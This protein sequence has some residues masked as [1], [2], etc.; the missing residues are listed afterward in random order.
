VAELP[1]DTPLVY[2]DECGVERHVVRKR[3]RAPRGKRIVVKRPGKREKRLNVVAGECDNE[4]IA[5]YAYDWTTKY[6]W[7]EI[8]FEW[9]LCPLLRLNSVVF[10]DNA[11]WHRKSVLEQIARF[12]SFTIIWLPT[13][14]P[15]KNRIEQ[16][17]A[18]LKFWLQ[19]NIND[20]PSVQDAVKDYFRS[21]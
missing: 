9:Y 1:S 19:Y 8:W 13:Y 2:V 6:T 7:F 15:D 10:M 16:R 20:Y 12:Y 4:V 18:N 11:S 21:D 17:W 5:P 14:S 3:V